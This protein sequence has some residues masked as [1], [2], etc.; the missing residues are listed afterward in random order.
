MTEWTTIRISKQLHGI[1]KAR[2]HKSEN[3]DEVLRRLLSI[4]EEDNA[5]V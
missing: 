2:G 3:F 5:G 4:P 1:L